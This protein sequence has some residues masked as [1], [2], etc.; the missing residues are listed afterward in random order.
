MLGGVD[1]ARAPAVAPG[2]PA[3]INAVLSSVVLTDTIGGILRSNTPARNAVR[4]AYQRIVALR[5][6]FDG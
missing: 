6:K 1:W 5:D 2:V 4:T 3:G